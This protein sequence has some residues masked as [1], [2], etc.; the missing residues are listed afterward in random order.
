[1]RR[2]DSL[3]KT[4]ML[5]KIEERR[6][7]GRQR[8]RWLDGITD[9]MDLS[10]SKLLEMVKDREAW[11]AVVHGIA[12]NWTW[13]G[14]CT[15][16][17]TTRSKKNFFWFSYWYGDNDDFGIALNV[18]VG[19]SKSSSQ[20]VFFFFFFVFVCLVLLVC[21]LSVW[22]CCNCPGSPDLIVFQR[23]ITQMHIFDL[24]STGLK[25]ISLHSTFP[26]VFKNLLRTVILRLNSFENW[27]VTTYHLPEK[28]K[29]KGKPVYI[30]TAPNF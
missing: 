15:T 19:L 29:K 18:T 2:A 7:R 5:G 16:T 6:R 4:L 11:R 3:E 30:R 22:F 24:M 21:S 10:F 27:P 28:W 13:L 25:L 12:E 8:I 20:P 9:S 26:S 17:T 1:M 14:H 23:N